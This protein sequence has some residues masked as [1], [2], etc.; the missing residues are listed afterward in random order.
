MR[1]R[2]R[3]IAGGRAPAATE[4]QTPRPFLDLGA[5]LFA[6]AEGRGVAL[7]ALQDAPPSEIA[8]RFC[9]SSFHQ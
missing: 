1:T 5:P 7:V 8:Y 3:L 2:L 9:S 6:F 4:P